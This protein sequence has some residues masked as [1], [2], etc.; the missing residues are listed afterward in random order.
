MQFDYSYKRSSQVSNTGD[1]TAM[2]FSPDLTRDPT[3]FRG[4]LN[5][6]IP[7]RE[8]ISALHDVVVSDARYKP[9]DRAEYMAW[10]EQ[11][12]FVDMKSVNLQRQDLAEEYERKSGELSEIYQSSQERMRPYYKAQKKYFDYLYKRDYDAWFV[13]DPVITVHPDEVF[14]E[15][16]SQDEASYGR[17]SA[18][19]EVFDSVGEFACGTT[20]VDYSQSLYEEFQKIR[21]Y[22]STRLEIDPSGFEV[23]T[24]MEEAHKEVKIDLPDSWVRGFL[25]VSSAMTLGA[26]EFDLHPMDLHNLCFVLRRKKELIGPRSM[27]YKLVPGQPIV[28][29]FDPWGTEVKCGRSIYKGKSER[30]IRVW[31]R[32]RIH[33]LERL[34][35]LAKRFRVTL[36]GTGMPS[37]YVADM[38]SMS[39]TL[40]LS[41]WTKNDWSQ[42]ANFDLMA[43][44]EE[45]DSHTKKQIFAAL[46]ENWFED[47]DS[48]SARLNLDKT[49]VESALAS[50]VQ[51]GRAIYDLNKGVYRVRELTQ[52][53]LP[54]DAL[55]FSNEREKKATALLHRGKVSVQQRLLSGGEQEFSGAVVDGGNTYKTKLVLD[56][57]R[58]MVFAECGCNFYQQNKL[59][60]GPCAHMLALR[61]AEHRGISDVV[62]LREAKSARK[63][64]QKTSDGVLDAIEEYSQ[65]ASESQ[66]KAKGGWLKRTWSSIVGTESSKAE[67]RLRSA[68]ASAIAEIDGSLATIEDK[69]ALLIDL[70]L[71]TVNLEGASAQ[72]STAALVIVHS[73]TVREVFGDTEDLV[74]IIREHLEKGSN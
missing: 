6:K 19:F 54:V 1:E 18:S 39:F 64:L 36:L 38:G 27:R 52:E 21:S 49:L 7:F 9:R 33:A 2:S 16:F 73:H 61:I 63:P 56:V 41:G 25:Q 35:P 20:N 70:H 58:K 30:E 15:C 14:F 23:Q 3:Y 42:S 13:L 51:A 8:A 31:G 50:Y 59:Y 69:D 17:L 57:E 45:V 22:K 28:V 11:Q 47:S 5:Q 72:A 26:V 29:V 12:D 67:A 55:R 32:R 37:F 65:D 68:L 66:D 44:R 71:A 60:K 34:I 24:T 40:G 53:P 62:D 74:I 10:L 48:L 43:P 46:K 4:Q